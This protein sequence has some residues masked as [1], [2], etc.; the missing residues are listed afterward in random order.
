VSRIGD[1]YYNSYDGYATDP[2]AQSFSNDEFVVVW[3]SYT[4]HYGYYSYTYGPGVTG[5]K[6]TA[7]GNGGLEFNVHFDKF[8]NEYGTFRPGMDVTTQDRFVVVWSKQE[9]PPIFDGK[10]SIRRFD[11]GTN[12]L[13]P[14]Q[15]INAGD[16]NA[17]TQSRN[18]VARDA[19]G[20]FLVV[21]EDDDPTISG[22]YLVK[23]RKFDSTGTPTTS[24]FQVNTS[25]LPLPAYVSVDS[26]ASGKFIVVW[27]GLSPG[28]TVGQRLDASG[29]PVGGEFQIFP[30]EN[31]EIPPRI[32]MSADGHFMVVGWD[33]DNDFSVSARTF[34][35]DGTPLSAE[36]A[37]DPTATPY[38]WYGTASADPDNHF[39][40]VWQN[41]YGSNL[42]GQ[43]F[44][45]NGNPDGS[46]FQVSD[47][48]PGFDIVN[49]GVSLPSVAVDSAGDFT[50]VWPNWYYF[51]PAQ[52]PSGPYESRGI[53]GRQFAVCGNGR[54]GRTQS[55]DDGNAT[56]LDGCSAQCQTETC[57][58]CAGEP[59]SCSAMP[60]CTTVCSDAGTILNAQLTMRGV[61]GTLGDE[62]LSL[63]GK[64]TG[65]N[66]AAG[67]YDPSVEGA[68]VAITG[69]GV[70]YQR[71]AP[72]PIPPGLVGSG[73]VPEDGWK[74]R[75]NA[76]N[77]TFVYKNVS[78]ALPPACAPASAN[79]LKSVKMKDRIALD[80][81]LQMKLKVKKGS[82]ASAPP[83]VTATIVLGQSP[84]AGA[85]G[86]CARVVF[87]SQI[88]TRYF[89]GI[90]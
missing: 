60:G 38:S 72:L 40:V 8:T 25:S 17:E 43:R 79:G 71:T 37:V 22:N 86:R 90:P 13:S 75:G 81:T 57:H 58:S 65:A 52:R 48:P 6:F 80:G 29:A 82:I 45:A 56:A 9:D 64:I 21:W 49:P 47:P 62:A 24:E 46:R 76:P 15:V 31:D 1:T 26:D 50:V 73:C 39:V 59:S 83:P 27:Q 23:A 78:G 7:D 54:I 32:A 11:Q 41:G 61:G 10:V 35:P 89:P 84:A 69:T 19:S 74:V 68:E 70:V 12:P 36:F 33:R 28:Q 55:C 2:R 18:D 16:A 85:A 4:Y 77:R 30:H 63:R 88:G 5:R 34:A 66:V 67:A 51:E 44:D 42:Y 53:W 20:G 87:T 3:E 14:E